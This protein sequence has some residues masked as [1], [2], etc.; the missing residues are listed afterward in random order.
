MRNLFPQGEF[1]GRAALE[2]FPLA[3]HS[4]GQKLWGGSWASVICPLLPYK[5]H[6]H[7]TTHK[8]HSNPYSSGHNVAPQIFQGDIAQFTR[9]ILAYLRLPTPK[10]PRHFLLRDPSSSP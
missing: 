3:D 9:L 7:R 4:S 2:A 6:P 5:K 8:F 1:S 10:T